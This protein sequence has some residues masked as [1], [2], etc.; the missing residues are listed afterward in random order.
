[1]VD[2]AILEAERK[3]EA[4][5]GHYPWDN[6]NYNRVARF[7][8]ALKESRIETTK[9]NKC[10][11]IQ[12]PPRIICSTCLS[13]DISWIELPKAGKI[14]AFSKA[15]VGSLQ[16]EESPIIVAAILL[17]N[18][19]R[20]LSRIS[21]ATYEQLHVGQKVKLTKAAMVNGQPYWAFSPE[22]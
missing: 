9:C 22:K 7:F 15:F 8:S 2:P 6:P 18:G 4:Q 11:E 3:S 20:L 14:V 1:M 5:E 10:G 21:D 12:W 17:D 16:G 19:L 13:T